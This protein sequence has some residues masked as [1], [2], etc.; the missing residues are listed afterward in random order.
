MAVVVTHGTT[1]L[2]RLA[3]RAFEAADAAKS[4][5][6]DNRTAIG[7]SITAI[8]NSAHDALRE[9]KEL[10]A[11][12]EHPTQSA[13][14]S[15]GAA[16]YTPD[17]DFE[18]DACSEEVCTLLIRNLQSRKLILRAFMLNSQNGSYQHHSRNINVLTSQIGVFEN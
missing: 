1:D 9:A 17:A 14:S 10:A 4:P 6:L 11:A 12:E 16:E 5:A 2:H 13:P 18:P 3:G 7:R 15:S 8:L